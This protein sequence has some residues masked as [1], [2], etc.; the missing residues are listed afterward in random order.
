MYTLKLLKRAENELLDSCE[1]YEKQ[2]KGLAR[3]FLNEL[4]IRF[5]LITKNPK[6]Y[7]TQGNGNLRCAPLTK[8]PYLVVYWYYETLKS[9]FVA[10]IFHTS[11]EPFL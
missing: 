6:L 5:K 1:W 9:V 8:F 2:K 4:E 3:R 7:Q 10:S 11:R